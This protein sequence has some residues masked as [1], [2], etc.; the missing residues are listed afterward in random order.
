MQPNTLMKT[1]LIVLVIAHVAC[2]IGVW[3]SPRGLNFLLALNASC[4]V[5]VL[6]Y[7]ASRAPYLIA[8]KDW[9]LLGLFLFEGA[10]LA[11]AF[12]AFRDSRSATIGSYIGF[13]L[14]AC[15]SLAA[16]AFAFVFKITKLM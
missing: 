16:L 11:G 15:T 5:A 7:L 14:H 6:L 8:A 2:L 3:G 1:I 10:V 13:G 12:A 9:P 4:A